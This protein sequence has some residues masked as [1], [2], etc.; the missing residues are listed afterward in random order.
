MPYMNYRLMSDED[1]A[2]VIVYIR[3]LPAVRRELPRTE[4]PFP[5][6]RLINSVPE[7]LDGPVPP[8][9]THTPELRGGREEPPDER[10]EKA[11]IGC[12]PSGRKRSS[13]IAEPCFDTLADLA[14]HLV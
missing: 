9:E 8:P 12:H 4:I 6:G 5:P 7:P 3:T 11:I 13:L 2:S 10:G 14:L 1:L